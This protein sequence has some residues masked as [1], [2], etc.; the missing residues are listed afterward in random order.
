MQ[1]REGGWVG[2]CGGTVALDDVDVG[3]LDHRWLHRK[4]AL[5]SQ[6]PVLFSGTIADNSRAAASSMPMPT[7]EV[8]CHLFRK[9]NSFMNN[10][11]SIFSGCLGKPKGCECGWIKGIHRRRA[12]R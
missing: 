4:V 11:K 3:E 5:V 2:L 12:R 8:G 9:L 6:E 10:D 7:I 1:P